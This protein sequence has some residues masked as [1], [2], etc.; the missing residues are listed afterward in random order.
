LFLGVPK[1]VF[2]RA[3]IMFTLLQEETPEERHV[4]LEPQ[5]LVRKSC[6]AAVQ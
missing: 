4:I 6:G 2:N 3:K 1:R 5:L